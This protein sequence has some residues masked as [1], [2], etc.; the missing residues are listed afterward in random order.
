VPELSVSSIHRDT[1]AIPPTKEIMKY[2]I[3]KGTFRI[4]SEDSNEKMWGQRI[5]ETQTAK[6]PPTV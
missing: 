1:C 5:H 2:N 4:L 6:I 3:R